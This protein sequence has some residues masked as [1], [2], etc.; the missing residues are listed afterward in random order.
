MK[1]DFELMISNAKH[2]NRK[3]LVP[4]LIRSQVYKDAQTL[5]AL[6]YE[7][8][9]SLQAAQ[10]VFHTNELRKQCSQFLEEIKRVVK[11][12]TLATI[13]DLPKESSVL[14]KVKLSN[15][16]EKP[17]SL[18][19]IQ[20]KVDQDQ[21]ATLSNFE[22]DIGLLISNMKAYNSQDL[23]LHEDAQKLAVFYTNQDSAGEFE[24]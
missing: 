18:K 3:G 15:K 10:L 7:N 1:E 19:Q 21:Y 23:D 24:F 13:K 4:N 9:N 14:E 12:E 11:P 17:I 8:I 6:F 2:Y 22:S 5:S 20:K 16:M